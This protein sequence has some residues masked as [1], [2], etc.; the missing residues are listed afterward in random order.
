MKYAVDRIEGDIAVLEN[1]DTREL[2]NIKLTELPEITDGDIIKYE[3]GKY[4]KD[5]ETQNKRLEEIKS[6]MELLKKKECDD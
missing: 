5:M 4:I 3:D 6:K 1:L 2:L